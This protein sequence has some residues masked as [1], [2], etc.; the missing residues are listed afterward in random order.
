MSFDNILSMENKDDGNKVIIIIPTYNERNNIESTIKSAISV[1]PK[2]AIMVVDD[3]SP[4]GTAEIVKNLIIDY[5]NLSLLERA[6]K[7]GLGDAYKD[8][9]KKIILNQNIDVVITMD[10]DGSHQPQYL[11]DFLKHIQN[12][13]LIIGSRYIP[14]GG[15]ENWELWRRLLSKFGNIYAKFLTGAKINDLTAGFMCI[16][17]ELLEKVNLNEINSTGYAYLMEFKIYCVEK[18]GASFKEVP[19]I[20][21]ERGRGESKMSNRIIGEGIKAPLR[22]FIKKLFSKMR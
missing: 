15:I 6:V 16:K 20:F 2:A 5:S 22:I 4:D 17:K 12:Y 1:L 21:K 3:N 14:G 13:D 11:N 19:I 9:I 10:G 18:L 8:A 7:T